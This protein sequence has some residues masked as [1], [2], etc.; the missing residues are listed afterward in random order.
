M[1]RLKAAN[2]APEPAAV[3]CAE[4]IS[5]PSISASERETETLTRLFGFM[6]RGPLVDYSHIYQTHRMK[7]KNREDKST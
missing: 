2:A 7:R 4:D 1:S 3:P 6:I 5:D